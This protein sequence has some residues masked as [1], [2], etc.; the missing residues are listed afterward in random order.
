MKPLFLCCKF[1]P[2]TLCELHVVYSKCLCCGVVRGRE[3]REGC[4]G[5]KR[6][7]LNNLS[8]VQIRLDGHLRWLR[9]ALKSIIIFKE[10][11]QTSLGGLKDADPG[12]DFKICHN[13]W[14]SW[15][16]GLVLLNNYIHYNTWSSRGRL[17]IRSRVD[18]FI[19]QILPSLVGNSLNVL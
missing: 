11:N 5:D 17:I 2:H 16:V 4:W 12:W 3:D 7:I 1:S 15:M 10:Y 18:V 19:I 6:L 9:L 14:M 8:S 13:P